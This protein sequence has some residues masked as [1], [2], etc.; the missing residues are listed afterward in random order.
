MKKKTNKKKQIKKKYINP[1]ISR[2]NI[3][4]TKVLEQLWVHNFATL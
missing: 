1:E 3:K 4:F 2:N